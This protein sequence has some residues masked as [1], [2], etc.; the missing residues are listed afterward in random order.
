MSKMQTEK[1]PVVT[2][3]HNI[4]YLRLEKQSHANELTQNKQ[5]KPLIIDKQ[6]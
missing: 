6:K 3:Y 5:T 4:P 2:I 1:L